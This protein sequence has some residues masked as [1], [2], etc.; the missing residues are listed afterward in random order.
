MTTNDNNSSSQHDAKLLVTRRDILLGRVHKLNIIR[1]DI[2]PE[3][4]NRATR[5]IISIER[6]LSIIDKLLDW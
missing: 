4:F 5:L 3:N 2:Y 6:K 1:N